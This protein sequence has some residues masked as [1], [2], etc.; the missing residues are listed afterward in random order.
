M[1][2]IKAGMCVLYIMAVYDSIVKIYIMIN[3]RLPGKLSRQITISSSSEKTVV[4]MLTY[5]R[6]VFL[7]STDS[8]AIYMSRIC[9]YVTA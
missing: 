6:F 3:T 8:S 1:N 7:N 2:C 9:V 4:A 5:V